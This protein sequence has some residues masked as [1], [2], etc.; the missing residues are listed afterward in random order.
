MFD[1]EYLLEALKKSDIKGY[2]LFPE[3][4]S[5]LKKN[6]IVNNMVEE[7]EAFA[8][9]SIQ[10]TSPEITFS[11]W[12]EFQ[13]SGNRLIFENAYF[14]RRKQLFSLVL[15]YLSEDDDKLIPV[16]EE[17]LWEWCELYSWELPAHF[18]MSKEA[19]KSGKSNPEHTV[20]LFAAESAFFFAEILYIIG[21]KLHELLVLR[22]ENE[23]KRRVIT[24]YKEGA[25]WWEDAKMNWSSV[26]A[27][28]VGAAA[29]YLIKDNEELA[30]ILE[31]VIKSMDAFVGAFDEDGLITEGLDYWSY[32]FSFFV[33]FSEL[34]KE[35][36]NG[37]ISLLN[38]NEKI[39]KIA[40]LPQILQF[41]SNAFVNFSDAASKKWTGDYG[42]FSRLEK[43]LNI[44]GYNYPEENNI[45]K[46]HTYRWAI[47]VRKLFWWSEDSISEKSEVKTGMFL[48]S[49]SQWLVDRRETESNEFVAFAAKGGH[50]DE[51]HNHND[52]GQFILHY[53]GHPIFIDIGAPEYLKQ[54]FR[55][56][57]R[58]DSLAASSI[59]HSVP[60]INKKPQMYGRDRHTELLSCEEIDEKTYFNLQIKEAYSCEELL[61]CERAFI[62]DYKNLQLILKDSFK[63]NKTDNEIQEVFI[64]EIKPKQV[65]S[66]VILI[67]TDKCCTELIYNT[68]LECTIEK[69]SYNNHSGREAIIYRTIFTATKINEAQLI[70]FKIVLNPKKI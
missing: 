10:V 46:D 55:N 23:I 41:P 44:K 36:T 9:N 4:R 62:W 67:E 2:E 30:L 68:K 35:R 33:Y 3:I 19:I 16:I 60:I 42:L 6:S 69:C 61:S 53:H 37:S 51:P 54:Y 14:L 47:M 66:G 70:E 17:K 24:P 40:Q 63:F 38:E 59:G 18:N 49:E 5:N 48:F 21:D 26:C 52:L 34:L 32:G 57:T 28:S 20:A 22:L 45:F 1:R 58:Y 27:G 29:I 13:S 65:E 15:S 50:N 11:M 56:E 7:I 25:F 39:K 31:R 43:V 8:Y 12:N 64:S